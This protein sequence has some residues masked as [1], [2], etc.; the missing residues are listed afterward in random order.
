MEY[1]ITNNNLPGEGL[2]FIKVTSSL[3]PTPSLLPPTAKSSLGT[4]LQ[5]SAGPDLSQTPERMSDRMPEFICHIYF[6]MLC[7]KLCQK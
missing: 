6:Q 1:R 3:P 7:Q 5:M 4:E 2:D